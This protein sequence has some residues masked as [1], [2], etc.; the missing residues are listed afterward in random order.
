MSV[1]HSVWQ[2][3]FFSLSLLSEPVT[4]FKKNN[5]SITLCVNLDSK[6]Q[7]NLAFSCVP[8]HSQSRAQITG[9]VNG[10]CLN[11]SRPQEGNKESARET[12][13]MRKGWKWKVMLALDESGDRVRQRDAH[14][15]WGQK[16]CG[17]EV[18][19]VRRIMHRDR[20]A[21]S[22]NT[23]NDSAPKQSDEEC[24]Q[25]LW[26]QLLPLGDMNN[27]PPVKKFTPPTPTCR[28]CWFRFFGL[29]LF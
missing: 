23:A 29:A 17:A 2:G 19:D 1:C 25:H 9:R 24:K 27:K 14:P 26:H 4:S 18:W 11:W 16:S 3:L 8:L 28:L 5:F 20:T 15:V 21:L 12:D 22:A 10:I 6:T 7:Q 13:K